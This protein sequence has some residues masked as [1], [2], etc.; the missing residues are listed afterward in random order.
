[1]NTGLGNDQ[2]RLLALYS[3]AMEPVSPALTSDI[4]LTHRYLHSI[5][6]TLRTISMTGHACFT[7]LSW[8]KMQEYISFCRSSA[9]LCVL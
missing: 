7:G 5:T 2:N 8:F 9:M 1:M 4:I 6:T 3:E